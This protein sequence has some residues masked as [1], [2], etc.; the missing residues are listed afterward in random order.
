MF[1]NNDITDLQRLEITFDI[2]IKKS[3]LCEKEV[4]KQINNNYTEIYN[5]VDML[6]SPS[7]ELH[8]INLELGIVADLI[9]KVKADPDYFKK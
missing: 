4:L 8:L 3:K 9:E 1:E 5:L 2:L 7:K 6:E